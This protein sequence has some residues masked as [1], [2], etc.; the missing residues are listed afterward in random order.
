[1][2]VLPAFNWKLD[3]VMVEGLIVSLNSAITVVPMLIAVEP[4]AG[5]TEVTVGGILSGPP[6]LMFIPGPAVSIFPLSSNERKRIL[7]VPLPVDGHV[8]DHVTVPSILLSV[9]CLQVFPASTDISTPA[10]TPPPAS[11]AVPVKLSVAPEGNVAPFAGEVIV[12]VGA[13]ASVDAVTDTIPGINVAGC[14]FI[15][16]NRLMV[17][18]CI[19]GLTE[20]LPPQW[21]PSR[22]HDH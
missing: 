11:T 19:S 14:T 18:C 4:L 7:K 6:T 12:A 9:A 21:L 20:A 8:K 13:I 16:A 2:I 3:D 10:T 15:S 17:A 22:P 5:V 1:M